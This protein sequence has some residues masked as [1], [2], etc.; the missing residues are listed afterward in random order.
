MLI[1]CFTVCTS[2]AVLCSKQTHVES[3]KAET[4]EM[5]ALSVKFLT[6]RHYLYAVLYA[7][8]KLSIS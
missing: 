4:C 7:G 6:T 1:T 3:S 2:F 8:L 5:K